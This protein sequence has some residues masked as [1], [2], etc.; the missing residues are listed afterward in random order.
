MET[1]LDLNLSHD[2]PRF[3]MTN[4]SNP[5]TDPLEWID[6][7]AA[8]GFFIAI[9]ILVLINVYLLYCLAQMAQANDKPVAKLVKSYANTNIVFVPIAAVL[10]FGVVGLMPISTLVGSW[11]CDATFFA[12]FFIEY[13]IASFSF[14]V[15]SFTY[16]CFVQERKVDTYGG[17]HIVAALFCKLHLAIPLIMAI[18][19]IPLRMYSP[20]NTYPWINKCHGRQANENNTGLCSFEDNLVDQA[21]GNWSNA[22]QTGLQTLCWVEFSYSV[23]L[24]SNITEAIFY[25]FIYSYLRK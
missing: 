12:A 25:F 23:I 8:V 10:T 21:F 15:A 14:V 4:L 7:G 1:K 17:T 20:S 24:N 3:P 5:D 22:A 16:V 18:V 6:T 9:M 2:L 11:F 13:Y 19:T